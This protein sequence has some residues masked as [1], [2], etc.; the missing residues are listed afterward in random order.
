MFYLYS[1]YGVRLLLYRY[2]SPP[3]CQR[4]G[5]GLSFKPFFEFFLVLLVF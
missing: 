4:S 2:F 5:L 3:H 1:V